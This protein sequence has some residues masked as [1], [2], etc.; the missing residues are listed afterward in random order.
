[1]YVIDPWTEKKDG[2]DYTYIEDLEYGEY[3]PGMAWTAEQKEPA[4]WNALTMTGKMVRDENGEEWNSIGYTMENTTFAISTNKKYATGVVFKA[5][6]TPS[7]VVS[8]YY[9]KTTLTEGETFFKWNKDLYATAEDIMAEIYPHQFTTDKFGDKIDACKTW[10]DVKTFAESLIEFDPF[11]YK[12][13]LL[14]KSDDNTGNLT[15]KEKTSLKWD[16][17]MK[18]QY[19]YSVDATGE[20][21][22]TYDG[23]TTIN[24]TTEGAVKAFKDGQCYYTWWIRHS[25][26]EDEDSNGVMEYAIVRNNIYCLRVKSVS[27]LGGYIPAEGL[28]CEVYVRPWR[29]LNS[30]TVDF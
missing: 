30:E 17:Y 18:E 9:G 11:G 13:N 27:T 6:F 21:E 20:V 8:G 4:Y 16:N 10:T 2:T 3:Y 12:K 22:I 23:V 26:D 7:Q 28:L 19:G 5:Q 15:D 24:E 25:N 14:E 29:V 1:N